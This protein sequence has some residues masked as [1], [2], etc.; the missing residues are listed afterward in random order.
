MAIDSFVPEEQGFVLDSE[1]PVYKEETFEKPESER[2]SNEAAFYNLT[3]SNSTNISEDFARVRNNIQDSGTDPGLEEVKQ[4]IAETNKQIYS[5]QVMSTLSDADLTLDQKKAVLNSSK[6]GIKEAGEVVL[7]EEFMIKEAAANI[8][9]KPEVQDVQDEILGD[10]L[11]IYR[12]NEEAKKVINKA[13]AD[14][15][16]NSSPEVLT[17]IL[18]D[19]V[20][21]NNALTFKGII[22]DVFGED[23]DSASFIVATGEA[24]KFIKDRVQEAQ[25]QDKIDLIKKLIEATN[26]RSGILSENDFTK[27]S[28]MLQMFEEILEPGNSNLGTDVDRIL[29]NVIGVLD[30]IPGLQLSRKIYQ[31]RKAYKL[32]SETPLEALSHVNPKKAGETTASAIE[33]QT[34]GI[35]KALGESKSGLIESTL[36]PK[37]L[38]TISYQK[39][40]ADVAESIENIQVIA[41]DIV[42]RTESFGFAFNKTQRVSA[43]RAAA[44]RLANTEGAT[45]FPN[46]S[47]ISTNTETISV[48]A[49]FGFDEN[50]GFSNAL[51]AQRKGKELFPE[52][53]ILILK[54]MKD[55]SYQPTKKLSGKGEFFFEINHTRAFDS[56]DALY[57]A[58]NSVNHRRLWGLLPTSP[59]TKFTRELSDI[60]AVLPS[61]NKRVIRDMVSVLK[62]F[63]QL[64]SKGRNL[65][66]DT[67]LKGVTAEKTFSYDDLVHLGLNNK[68]IKGYYSV[69]GLYD[70]QYIVENRKIYK[71]LRRDGMLHI[72]GNKGID[73]TRGYQGVAAPISEAEAVA[74]AGSAFDPNT[75]GLRTLT[76]EDVASIYK[77]GGSIG[78]TYGRHIE[79]G[80]VTDYII[81]EG[82]NGT[83]TAPLPAKVLNYNPGHATT[84]YKNKYFVQEQG[85]RLTNGRVAAYTRTINIAGTR[86]EAESMVAS[87]RKTAKEGTTYTSRVDR[88][89]REGDLASSEIDMNVNKGALFTGK[90]SKR[91][92]DQVGLAEIADPIEALL[93]TINTVAKHASHTDVIQTMKQ[94][95]LN[96]YGSRFNHTFPS[97]VNDFRVL[98]GADTEL[99]AQLKDS[100]ALWHYIRTLEGV[101]TSGKLVDIRPKIINFGEWI[102]GDGSNRVRKFVGN[103][104]IDQRDIDPLG[105]VR[106]L[107]FNMF[108]RAN[109][110]RQAW[111]QSGQYTF[112]A[113][114]DPRFSTFIF[115][116]DGLLRQ[117]LALDLGMAGGLL[118]KLDQVKLHAG[119]GKMMGISGEEF[120]VMIDS[121][122]KSGLPNSIDSNVFMRDNLE[123]YVNMMFKN[124]VTKFITALA[125]AP[126]KLLK[127]S[128]KVGFEFG[129]YNNLSTTWLLARHKRLLEN[130]GI[131]LAARETGDLISAD[132]RQYSLSMTKEG[133]FGYQRNGF[134]STILQF[135]SIQHKALEAMTPVRLGGSQVFTASQKR[136]IAVGQLV[137]FGTK[138]Y[139]IS[140]GYKYIRDKYGVTPNKEIDSVMEGG[141][142]EWGLNKSLQYIYDDDTEVSISRSMSPMSGIFEANILKAT[143]DLVTGGKSPL[144]YVPGISAG[145]RVLDAFK[146][147]A[148]LTNDP[149]IE[150]KEKILK[151]LQTSMGAFS[152]YN[153][154]VK[155][156][157]ALTLGYKVSRLG[158]PTVSA[159]YAEAML[160]LFGIQ[161]LEEQ[162]YYDLMQEAYTGPGKKESKGYAKIAGEYYDN[163]TRKVTFIKSSA[164]TLD[165]LY[166][167]RVQEQINQESIILSMFEP[168]EREAI[169]AEFRILM[170][171]R[172]EDGSDKIVRLIVEAAIAGEYGSEW[173]TV[174]TK[175]KNSALIDTPEEE[176]M[177][178]KLWD[179]MI[180]EQ[181]T[182][183]ER[184]IN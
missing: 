43:E 180:I 100:E 122:R 19:A 26:Q 139:G 22:S 160:Q 164:T 121:F 91:L 33:D 81:I 58:E 156:R 179:S 45:Y 56:R 78:K 144:E 63:N 152:G 92:M 170:K 175:L 108:L 133:S 161:S 60:G 112:L 141:L 115:S 86:Q 31:V 12:G 102:L 166:R 178:K 169:I 116:K 103:K 69:R 14:L 173:D 7:V 2:A 5:E 61:V 18:A 48:R 47:D 38:D 93:K 98:R 71:Q 40:P 142:L 53:E 88:S 77:E 146:F 158:D 97:E 95:W 129:E 79:D 101:D 76:A 16:Q 46:L 140:E 104:V 111:V 119:L 113:A 20:P 51:E 165:E 27:W 163:L 36:Y 75:G 126:K 10:V 89:M 117:K 84:I 99:D 94:K 154:F 35:A 70:I 157:V 110:L 105:M 67:I 15:A 153:N 55:G 74:K 64:N 138:A 171:R 127:I 82:K 4:T 147:A 150:T 176:Q 42:E 85:T 73:G 159:T 130:P 25:G 124:D 183:E 162:D 167:Q 132:A 143:S 17:N 90:R 109:P 128:G 151:V 11:E 118:T 135:V 62:P 155:T 1:L 28:V 168:M 148:S 123:S 54:R 49:R 44:D 177:Y 59:G 184:E 72:T 96:T 8:P 106:S 145:N 23:A 50:Y 41:D 131:D 107:G 172:I 181:N 37:P 87:L 9:D 52:S 114:L 24:L 13:F 182:L 174:L 21:L 39:M 29:N 65:V 136:R 32:A 125:G 137:L 120:T 57:F 134:L 6:E 83:R 66:S 30:V 80:H 3:L 68:E 149:Q 34:G